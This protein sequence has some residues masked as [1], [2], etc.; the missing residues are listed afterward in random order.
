MHGVEFQSR[1][2]GFQI[3]V[4]GFGLGQRVGVTRFGLSFGLQ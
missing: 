1:V 3:M 2:E 4:Q